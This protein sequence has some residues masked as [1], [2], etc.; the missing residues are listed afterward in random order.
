[1]LGVSPPASALEEADI[2][3]LL[4]QPPDLR[5]LEPGAVP[6]D[7]AIVTADTISSY[8]LTIPSLWWTQTEFG[9]ELLDNWIA[10]PGSEDTPPRV[11]LIVSPDM[12]RDSNYWER[13]AFLLKFGRASESFG[14]ITRIFAPQQPEPVLL[15]A[16]ICEPD[17]VVPASEAIGSDAALSEALP[18]ETAPSSQSGTASSDPPCDIYLDLTGRSASRG[19]AEQFGGF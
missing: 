16:Y 18:G 10:Y 12:W 3:L 14:Y 15:A 17:Y 19:T 8:R 6:P 1:M 4:T 9:G 11:D 13:Y 2:Q 7:A 5:L